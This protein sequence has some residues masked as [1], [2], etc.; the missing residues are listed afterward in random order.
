MPAGVP[1]I[2]VQSPVAVSPDQ[3]LLATGGHQA[4]TSSRRLQFDS[5]GPP[6]LSPEW[7]MKT[8]TCLRMLLAEIHT[9]QPSRDCHELLTSLSPDE[10]AC[11]LQANAMDSAFLALQ[12]HFAL[13]RRSLCRILVRCSAALFTP[14]IQQGLNEKGELR[15]PLVTSWKDSAAEI[16]PIAE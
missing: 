16:L 6:S 1:V 7:L 12:E 10:T 2:E 11:A 15:P 4:S 5:S 9:D 3:Q 14:A 13:L 8:L